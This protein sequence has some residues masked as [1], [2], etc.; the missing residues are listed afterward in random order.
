M[1]QSSA[2]Y[3]S[4]H[5]DKELFSYGGRSKLWA[6]LAKVDFDQAMTVALL[7]SVSSEVSVSEYSSAKAERLEALARTFHVDIA[8]I[9]KQVA[10]EV[11]AR[12]HNVSWKPGPKQTPQ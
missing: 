6:E 3:G 1:L 2:I 4:R 5:R 10:A 11:A 8:A 7:A 12:K 9:R